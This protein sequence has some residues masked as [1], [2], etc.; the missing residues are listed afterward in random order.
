MINSIKN[1]T[2][3]EALAKQKLDV[4]NEIKKAEIK[5]KR[6]I[7]S[8]KKLLN[9][10]DDLLEAI[11]N[12]NKN[13]NENNNVSVNENENENDSDNDND[14]NDDDD[15]DDDDDHDEKCYIIKQLNNYFKT[16]DETKS[17][18]EQ[19]EILKKRDF[20]DEYWH[21]GYYHDDKEL[22]LRI[23]K[24]KATYILNDLGKQLF[25]KIFGH[26]FAALADKLINT[27]NKEENKIIIDDI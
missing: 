22:N 10:F 5:N 16:I 4:L 15:D 18:K 17:L 14:D 25:E 11:F 6:L 3:S 8:Q 23:F 13:E 21:V 24:A 20:L 19:I 9:L 27:T 1:N 2:I 26:T 12:N 7:S